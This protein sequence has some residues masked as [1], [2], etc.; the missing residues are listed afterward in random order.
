MGYSPRGQEESDTPERLSKHTAGNPDFSVRLL[1]PGVSRDASASERMVASR[2][3]N[4]SMSTV[5]LR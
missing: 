4:L 3:V 5:A 2:F 1:Q